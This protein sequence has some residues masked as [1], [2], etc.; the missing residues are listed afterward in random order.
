M[1]CDVLRYAP[2]VDLGQSPDFKNCWGVEVDMIFMFFSASL[3]GFHCGS[4]HM[5]FPKG[6]QKTCWK[7][8]RFSHQSIRPF[9]SWEHLRV[10][11]LEHLGKSTHRESMKGR[12]SVVPQ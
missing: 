11:E 1:K 3:F 12:C 10:R 6:I 7:C 5:I 8:F 2:N 9:T 4:Y